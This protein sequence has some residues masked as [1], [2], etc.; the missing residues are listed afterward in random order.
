MSLQ[1][2]FYIIVSLTLNIKLFLFLM[3]QQLKK[4]LR[5]FMLYIVTVSIYI[6]IKKI[7][8]DFTKKLY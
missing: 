4:T 8:S 2:I 5:K 7:R 6:L 3:K 1:K